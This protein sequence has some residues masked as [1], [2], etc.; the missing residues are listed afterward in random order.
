MA[1]WTFWSFSLLERSSVYWPPSS[2]GK[3]FRRSVSIVF[4]T[5]T[6]AT[7][8]V[9]KFIANGSVGRSLL[10]R[11]TPVSLLEY[12]YFDGRLNQIISSSN[13]QQTA[14]V[15]GCIRASASSEIQLTESGFIDSKTSRIKSA[16][17]K[18]LAN[19][20]RSTMSTGNGPSGDQYGDSIVR[21][22]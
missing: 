18:M 15:I 21:L 7:T 3:A 8:S 19:K 22:R 20:R 10:E 4:S 11:E 16:D 12:I 13:D 17:P 2:D 5:P 6:N 1:V 9:G 14:V